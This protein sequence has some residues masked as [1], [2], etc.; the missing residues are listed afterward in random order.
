MHFEQ[1]PVLVCLFVISYL[2]LF[3]RLL[4]SSDHE[5]P[6]FS[7]VV[8]KLQDCFFGLLIWSALLLPFQLW[9]IPLETPKDS[10]S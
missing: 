1:L 7:R 2:F 8:L 5:S 9:L 4:F 3:P 6:F 10:K